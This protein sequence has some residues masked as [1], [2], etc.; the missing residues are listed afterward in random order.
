[1]QS[2]ATSLESPAN[3][4]ILPLLSAAG[5]YHLNMVHMPLTALGQSRRDYS[6][7]HETKDSIEMPPKPTGEMELMKPW[8]STVLI[9]GSLLALMILEGV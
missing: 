5:P 6:N 9:S 1:M 3:R 7:N 2:I 8:Q 4:D